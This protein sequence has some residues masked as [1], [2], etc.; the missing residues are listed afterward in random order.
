[1]SCLVDEG[2]FVLFSSELSRNGPARA[3]TTADDATPEPV[4]VQALDLLRQLAKNETQLTEAAV[5]RAFVGYLACIA[6]I[7][8]ENQ[9]NEIKFMGNGRTTG[10]TKFPSNEG[11]EFS[12][13]NVAY[14][15]QL[16]KCYKALKTVIGICIAGASHH[17][18]AMDTF[19]ATIMVVLWGVHSV[20][21]THHD[22]YFKGVMGDGFKVWCSLNARGIS[23]EE[24]C[25][26]VDAVQFST[27][28]TITKVPSCFSNTSK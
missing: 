13:D 6:H 26:V 24:H 1:V 20:L 19:N 14:I 12:K 4:F 17:P 22:L 10:L 5:Q 27:A 23:T 18:A 25:L 28:A 16:R 8:V 3:P 7:P 15:S 21:A 11:C 9:F 2:L